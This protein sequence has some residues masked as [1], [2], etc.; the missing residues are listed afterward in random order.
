MNQVSEEV[1]L[2]PTLYSVAIQFTSERNK[3]S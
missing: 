3:A 1:D 2:L